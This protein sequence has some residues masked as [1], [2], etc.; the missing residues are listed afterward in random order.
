MNR[1]INK[2]VLV[3]VALLL[4]TGC[5]PQV[6]EAPPLSTEDVNAIKANLEAWVHAD[7]AADWDSFFAQFT[8]DAVWMYRP[9]LPAVEGLPEMHALRAFFTLTGC[10]VLAHLP[11][12][13]RLQGVLH[14]QSAAFD[15]RNTIMR[16]ESSGWPSLRSA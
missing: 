9:N 11:V 14:T 2:T 16:A 6:P 15:E 13:G 12:H 1:H 10:K 4:L 5:Q 8:D 3:V 7:L